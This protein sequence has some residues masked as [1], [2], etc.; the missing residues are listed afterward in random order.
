MEGP[1]LRSFM[2]VLCE[3]GCKISDH[4]CVFWL[5]TCAFACATVC[6]LNSQAAT[7]LWWYVICG[8]G[9]QWI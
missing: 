5:Y 2:C 4:K 9:P 7:Y 3:L 6:E 8:F 1:N